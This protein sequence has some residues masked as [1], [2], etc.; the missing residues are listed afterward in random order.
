MAGVLYI[1]STPIGN[2]EDLTFRALKILKEVAFIAAEDP[3]RTKQLLD[4]YNVETPLTA[5][6]NLNKEAK[7]PVFIKRLLE[8]ESLAI[9]SDAG[10]PVIADPGYFLISQALASG[11]RVVPIPGPSAVLAAITAS[12]LPGETFAFQGFAPAKSQPRRRF[13]E[14]L[15]SEPHTII[16]FVSWNQLRPMLKDICKLLGAR[17]LVLA[18]DLTTPH[19]EFIRGP[20]HEV[21]RAVTDRSVRGDLTLVIEGCISPNSSSERKRRNA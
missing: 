21:L 8:G 18:K 4:H 10:T 14:K 9:V 13:L 2:P 20:S 11:I 7:A 6:Y 15:R 5:Y 12:G 19:E 17:Y 16:L 3:H 1:V